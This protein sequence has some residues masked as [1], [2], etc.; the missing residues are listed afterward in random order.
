MRARA[1]SL[2]L[3]LVPLEG[4][5]QPA[6][7]SPT[8]ILGTVASDP[9]T[10]ATIPLYYQGASAQALRSVHLEVEFV[11]NSVKFSRA[12]KG[13]AAQV[14]DFDLVVEEREQPPD[15]KGIRRSRLTINVSAPSAAA[16]PE[17]L[18]AFLDFSV[19]PDAKAFSIALNPVVALARDTNGAAV[20]VVAEAGKII[21]AVPEA[22]LATCFF[23]TH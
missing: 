14:Q 5:A 20:S 10:T 13:A 16:L 2:L 7:E 11:S 12:Q 17:G 18:W 4:G 9:G 3:A 22:P 23:F 21:V 6:S 8:L 19:P 1:A 15:D